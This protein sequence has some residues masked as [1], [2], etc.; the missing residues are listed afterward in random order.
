MGLLHQ[1]MGVP[2]LIL[3]QRVCSRLTGQSE[4]SSSN[5]LRLTPLSP[6]TWL[7][8]PHADRRAESCALTISSALSS[9]SL[10]AS[11]G[12]HPFHMSNNSCRCAQ[13]EKRDRRIKMPFSG[14][15]AEIECTEGRRPARLSA[16]DWPNRTFI[17]VA[18]CQNNG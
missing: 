16:A 3:P 11:K 14:K 10:M 1:I 15:Q 4:G 6:L 9:G 8:P 17:L 5:R 7:S 18:W 13:S 2:R 12:F